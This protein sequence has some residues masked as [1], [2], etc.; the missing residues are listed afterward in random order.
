[1]TLDGTTSFFVAVHALIRHDNR[2]LVLRRASNCPYEASR[3][4]L[5]GGKVKAG[6]T[7]EEALVREVAEETSL[8]V[9]VGS[10][11]RTYTN[12]DSFPAQQYFEV[13]FECEQRAGILGLSHEHNS[14]DWLSVNELQALG[15]EAR[16]FLVDLITLPEF[17]GP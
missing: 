2:Y 15:S 11:I 10:P 9:Q 12:L 3:W 5:P 7:M 8:T 17:D 6:E 16:D 14:Y 13:T 1:L 4:E